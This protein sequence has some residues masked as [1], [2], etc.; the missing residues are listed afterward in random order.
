MATRVIR[1]GAALAGLLA[2]GGF[3]P[4]AQAQMRGPINPNFRLP[5]GPGAFG[6]GFGFGFGGGFGGGGGV[7]MGPGAGF[8]Q[9]NYTPPVSILYSPGQYANPA[10]PSYLNNTGTA[11]LST[12]P[13]V[14]VGW[15]NVTPG[16]D[17]YYSD[18]YMSSYSPAGG[19]LRGAADL[20]AAYGNFMVTN[21]R[22][23]LVQEEA[24]RSMIDTRRRVWE[25]A[26]WERMNTIWTEDYRESLIKNEQRRARLEPPLNEIWSGRTLNVLLEATA[27]QQAKGVRGQNVTIP[28]D[29]LKHINLTS[30]APNAGNIGLFKGPLQWPVALQGPEFTDVIKSL[31]QRI[32]DAVEQARLNNVVPDGQYKDLQR[33]VARLHETLLRNVSEMVPSDYIESKRYLN[34]LSEAVRALKDPKAQDYLTG[35]TAAKGKTVAELVDNMTR[36]QGLQFAP[37]SPGDEG[38]YRAL[39]RA[40]QTYDLSM[41]Q[42]NTSAPVTPTPPGSGSG[43]K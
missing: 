41:T 5:L 19:Y 3:V 38:A 28:D 2:L 24:N 26:K 15:G 36:L 10:L 23:R 21:Q 7:F 12:T 37:A 30:G 16:Y 20:T 25:E 18:P 22:A 14:G 13:G 1:F 35:K 43:D 8:A 31:N 32:P 34:M 4:Q 6:S 29:V 11:T 40:L 39:Y 17:P 9:P 27:A 33:D 42:L